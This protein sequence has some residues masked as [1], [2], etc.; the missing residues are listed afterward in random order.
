ML[1]VIVGVLYLLFVFGR[2]MEGGSVKNGFLMIAIAFAIFGFLALIAYLF[3]EYAGGLILGSIFIGFILWVAISNLKDTL[4]K[5]RF[6]YIVET[7]DDPT[8]EQLRVYFGEEYNN[9][10]KTRENY[11]SIYKRGMARK[12]LE[13]EKKKR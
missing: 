11:I 4:K 8:E 6:Q 5:N 12:I 1:I 3:D 13:E 2:D 10:S 9:P 7:M